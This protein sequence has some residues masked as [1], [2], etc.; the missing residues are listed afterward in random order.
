MLKFIVI[1]TVFSMETLKKSEEISKEKPRNLWETNY[2][3]QVKTIYSN[4]KKYQIFNK[5]TK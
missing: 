1:T 4:Y 2:N 3:Y 5:F